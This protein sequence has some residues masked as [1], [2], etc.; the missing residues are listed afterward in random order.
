MNMNMN[1]NNNNPPSSGDNRSAPSPTGTSQTVATTAVTADD[2]DDGSSNASDDRASSNDGDGGGGMRPPAHFRE[3]YTPLNFNMNALVMMDGSGSD[4]D[5]HGDSNND[6]EMNGEMFANSGYYH[7]MGPPPRRLNG[8]K[9]RVLGLS[10][11]HD[12]EED[13]ASIHTNDS[14][15]INASPRNND[16]AS[17]RSREEVDVP[18]DFHLLAEQAL[19]GLEVEHL[20]TLERSPDAFA[21]PAVSSQASNNADVNAS[22]QSTEFEACFQSFDEK[23]DKTNNEHELSADDSADALKEAAVPMKGEKSAAEAKI[24]LKGSKP[25]KS[26]PMDVGAIQKAMRSIRLKSPDLALTL[27]AG[28]SSFSA[29]ATHVATDAALDEIFRSVSRNIERSGRQQN[30]MSHAIIPSGPLAAFRRTTPK[31][32]TASANLTRSATLSE[33]VVRLWPLICFR[34]RMRSMGLGG[35][36]QQQQQTNLCSK[37]LTIHI[38]GA[39]GVECASEELVC[40]LIGS[41][42]RWVD[43]ALRSG[44]L[45]SERQEGGA[46][47][48]PAQAQPDGIDSL[49]IDFSGPNMPSTLIG[50]VLDLL[51]QSNSQSGGLVSAKAVFQRREYH[52][53]PSDM[54]D[55]GVDGMYALADLAVA[56][57]AGVWGY[58][59]WKPTIVS[60]VDKKSNGYREIGKTLFVITAYTVEECEDDAEV[61]TE[62]MKDVATEWSLSP[63]AI[64]RQLWA[65]EANPFSSRLERITASAPPGRNYYENGAWQAWLLGL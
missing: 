11:P 56:F 41:F 29:S 8:V 44:T 43:A 48:T 19:R 40:K 24:Q 31:A 64:A 20:S 51:P 6:D 52:E 13:S 25:L 49:L 17:S 62:V 60:M 54:G 63:C 32:Q 1:A 33:A 37:T 15:S 53:D 21:T 14:A 22:I 2:G 26:K 35:S 57:N 59:S 46:K 9:D 5:S 36:S 16:D 61:V 38:L 45:S 27:D 28:A 58:D 4:S 47:A 65:P 10:M 12:H 23:D 7:M 42:V 30:V 3:G 55:H 50:R 39:D 18:D 34:R